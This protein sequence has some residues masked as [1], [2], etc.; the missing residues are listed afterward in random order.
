[1]NSSHN[2]SFCSTPEITSVYKTTAIITSTLAIP[3]SISATVGNFSIIMALIKNKRLQTQSNIILGSLCVTDLLIGVVVLPVFIAR[4][5]M[6]IS[7]SVGRDYCI[8]TDF[9]QYISYLMAGASIVTMALI[10]L[11][12]W[13]AICFP[14]KYQNNESKSRYIIIILIIW[15]IMIVLLLLPFIGVEQK[16][17]YLGAASFVGLSTIIIVVCYFNIYLVVLRHKRKIVAV[18]VSQVE[19]SDMRTRRPAE[20]RRANTIAIVILFL[21]ICYIPHGVIISIKSISKNSMY[22]ASRW[23]EL[24]VLMNGCINPVV[25]CWRSSDIRQELKGLFKWK[26]ERV[27][28]VR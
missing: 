27:Q 4:R 12:R 15:L 13:F 22:V 18:S 25:Y 16:A 1:M 7:H 11:D 17:L 3:L 9:H 23:G 20:K 6:E 28:F 19:A 10:S 21:I 5:M 24:V 2:H 8:L 14:F 26:N